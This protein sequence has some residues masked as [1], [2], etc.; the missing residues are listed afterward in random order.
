MA[1]GLSTT[2]LLEIEDL[3]SKFVS[4]V[5]S[6]EWQEL[7]VAF[8]NADTIILF[9]HGG[10]MAIADHAAIDIMR[11]TDKTTLCPGSAI[12][13]SS[14]V[15]AFNFEQWITEWLKSAS[16]PINKSKCIVLGISC[17][18]DNPSSKSITSALEYIHN[19]GVSAHLICAQPKKDKD[20][21]VNIINQNVK[22]YHV[23][24]V[25]SLLLCYQLITGAG[26]ECPKIT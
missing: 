13:M 15:S 16:K 2:K 6:P 12:L 5:G 10:N 1:D 7:Q 3:G 22:H 20:L 21:S 26:F 24:E 18:I 8:N 19:E 14:L 9:G 25:L 23:S 4:V 11:L 17:S